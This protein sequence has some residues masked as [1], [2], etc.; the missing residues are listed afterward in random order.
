MVDQIQT[1]TRQRTDTGT[2]TRAGERSSAIAT[3]QTAERYDHIRIAPLDVK[4]CACYT[5]LATSASKA[6]GRPATTRRTCWSPSPIPSFPTCGSNGG[7]APRSG[8]CFARVG[9]VDG[10]GD[11]RVFRVPAGV[12]VDRD[13]RTGGGRAGFVRTAGSRPRRRRGL[14]VGDRVRGRRGTRLD[15]RD[16]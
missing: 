7:T 15:V 8:R 9:C 16:R 5:R 1:A 12:R 14:T 2:E 4:R 13:R 10:D 11:E 6:F 3:L